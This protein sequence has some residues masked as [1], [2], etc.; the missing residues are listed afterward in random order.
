VSVE[1]V[2]AAL[3]S[4]ADGTAPRTV[5]TDPVDHRRVV[6][7]ANRSMR[8]VET[9]AAFVS[10]GGL[11]RL[12]DAVR[13]AR[14]RGDE[15]VARR[16]QAVLE[17]MAEYRCAAAGQGAVPDDGGRASAA[18]EAASADDVDDSTQDAPG[19]DRSR[20]TILPGDGQTWDR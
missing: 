7:V 2:R 4:L 11:T 9:A 12:S 5:D 10:D 13:G 1:T 20:G 17:S 14:R 15:D 19:D 18:D 16:G 6:R 8:R 3:A